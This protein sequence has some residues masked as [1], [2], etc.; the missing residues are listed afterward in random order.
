MTRTTGVPS[1][2]RRLKNAVGRPAQS[3]MT[4]LSAGTFGPISSSSAA[5]SCGL[6]D[7]ASTSASVTAVRL[8]T[9]RTP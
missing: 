3:E 7:T 5:A 1:G 2:S 9:T 6:T 8:S 4:S